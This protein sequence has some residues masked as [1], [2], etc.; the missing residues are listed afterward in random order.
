MSWRQR[1]AE[2][3]KKGNMFFD[4][5]RK[6]IWAASLPSK[7]YF[8]RVSESQKSGESSKYTMSF[9]V[10]AMWFDSIVTKLYLFRCIRLALLPA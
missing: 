6:L 10:G 3:G 9:L 1:L 2:G 5:A 7:L 8:A 4:S